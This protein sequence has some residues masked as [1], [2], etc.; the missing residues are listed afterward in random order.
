MKI[1]AVY[2]RLSEMAE[3]PE[4]EA[5]PEETSEQQAPEIL[6]TGYLTKQSL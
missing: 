2:S 5:R 6:K 4:P 1:V 3:A